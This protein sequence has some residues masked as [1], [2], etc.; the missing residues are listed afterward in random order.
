[1][2]NYLEATV[3]YDLTKNIKDLEINTGFILGL[4]AILMY[5]FANVVEDP[6]TLA[7][8][9]KKFDVILSGEKDSTKIPTLTEI[10]RQIYTLFA[11]QQLLK[12]KAKEQ[13]LEVALESKVT[14]DDVTEYLK[15]IMNDDSENAQAKLEKIQALITTKSS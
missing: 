7:T 2:E 13:N 5:Y 14:K 4:D 11:I 6:S 8:T 10:E 3:T 15:L 1:M 9:F 12:A